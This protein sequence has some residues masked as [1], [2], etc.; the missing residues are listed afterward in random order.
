MIA[1]TIEDTETEE[2]SPKWQRLISNLHQMFPGISELTPNSDLLTAELLD[3]LMDL[4]LATANVQPD[5]LITLISRV[6][7]LACI[8]GG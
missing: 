8:N 4:Q 7:N 5:F 1:L 2:D 3:L 6:S